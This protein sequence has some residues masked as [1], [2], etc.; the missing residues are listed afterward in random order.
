VFTLGAVWAGSASGW[1]YF[2]QGYFAEAHNWVTYTYQPE[3]QYI[4]NQPERG[5]Y[6][7]KGKFFQILSIGCVV[8]SYLCTIAGIIWRGMIL[9]P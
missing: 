1:A 2:A 5:T 6:D 9:Q 7:G 4:V 3:D 8:G